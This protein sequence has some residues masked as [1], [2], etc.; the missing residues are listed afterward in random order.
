MRA[1]ITISPLGGL[2]NRM[3]AILSA[4]ALAT[5]AGATLK[6]LWNVCSELGCEPQWLFNTEYW[7]FEWETTSPTSHHWLWKPGGKSNLYIPRLW[8][9]LLFAKQIHD[10]TLLGNKFTQETILKAA[11]KRLYITSGLCFY[12]YNSSDAAKLFSPTQSITDMANKNLSMMQGCNKVGVH[13]RRT[14]NSQSIKHS[15]DHLFS[16][17][18][19][20]QIFQKPDTMFYLATDSTDVK[21][22]L[23]KE[24]GGRIVTS[25]EEACR[26]SQQGIINAWAE[27]LTL[28]RMNL[29]IG[30]FYSSFSEMAAQIGNTPLIMATK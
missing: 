9:S 14:D 6:V 25:H 8:Q 27:M 20:Q 10:H 5:D 1:S 15:P 12:P 19:R 22:K 30:S 13:I 24:F 26:S 29:I 11:D 16:S 2:A 21:N 3:R 4:R 18:I 17:M 7:D 28:S 23:I